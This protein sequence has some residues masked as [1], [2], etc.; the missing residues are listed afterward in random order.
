MQ[1]LGFLDSKAKMKLIRI[2]TVFNRVTVI[3]FLLAMGFCYLII[4]YIQFSG[5]RLEHIFHVDLGFFISHVN[6]LHHDYKLFPRSVENIGVD[7]KYHYFDSHI[8]YFLSF[9]FG[10]QKAFL[11]FAIMIFILVAYLFIKRQHSFTGNFLV[12]LF[13]ITSPFSLYGDGIYSEG[14]QFAS[15]FIQNHN[16]ILALIVIFLWITVKNTYVKSVLGVLVGFIKLPLIPALV[17]LELFRLTYGRKLQTQMFKNEAVS[18]G[19]PLL[20]VIVS[21]FL[22]GSNEIKTAFSFVPRDY[23]RYIKTVVNL[24]WY[25]LPLFFLVYQNFREHVRFNAFTILWIVG[26]ALFPLAT[27][28]IGITIVPKQ[29]YSQDGKQVFLWVYITFALYFLTQLRLEKAYN[30]L[31]L[32]LFSICLAANLPYYFLMGKALVNHDYS[33]MSEHLDNTELLEATDKIADENKVIGMNFVDNPLRPKK[34]LQVCAIL[35]NQLFVSNLLYGGCSV[36]EKELIMKNWHDIKSFIKTGNPDLSGTLEEL[37]LDK[38]KEP[39]DLAVLSSRY[40]ILDET[41]NYYLLER[42]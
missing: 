10:T 34:Q 15:D 35:P 39:F 41:Q 21:Y 22:F 26:L 32:G 6:A 2:S 29:Y 1:L 31:L 42:K 18:S 4:N 28:N 19:L 33:R 36:Q 17:L 7:Y 37:L 13:G 30:H 38:R 24:W 40:R 9:I 5:D 8:K 23:W 16:T 27:Q 20:A 3:A 12:V 14:S 11:V 25:Y